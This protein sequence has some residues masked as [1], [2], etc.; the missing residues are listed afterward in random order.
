MESINVLVVYCP[1]P[2]AG[3]ELHSENKEDVKNKKE[4]KKIY[5]LTPSWRESLVLLLLLENLSF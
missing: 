4:E 2:N 5:T 3:L 1:R